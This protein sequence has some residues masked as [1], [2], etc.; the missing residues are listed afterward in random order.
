MKV[1]IFPS[2]C[3]PRVTRL[4][5]G[6]GCSSRPQTLPICVWVTHTILEHTRDAWEDESHTKTVYSHISLRINN[7][8]FYIC[9][10]I[11]FY[12]KFL[13]SWFVIIFMILF[14]HHPTKLSYKTANSTKTHQSRERFA[15]ISKS[16]EFWYHRVL[17]N[18]VFVS[19]SISEWAPRLK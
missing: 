5:V 8:F 15:V 10:K 7:H 18:C 9:L 1:C 12:F 6:G 4:Q 13:F 16:E 14:L 17:N 3:P 19:D 2:S 11:S